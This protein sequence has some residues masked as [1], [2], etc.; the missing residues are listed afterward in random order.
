M[1]HIIK[2]FHKHQANHISIINTLVREGM[3]YKG[4]HQR[5]S[6]LGNGR[7]ETERG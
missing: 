6:M 3:M 4:N 5:N 2:F 1:A 7:V